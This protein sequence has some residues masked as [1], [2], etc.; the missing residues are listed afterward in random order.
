MTLWERLRAAYGGR[1]V[2]VTGH[3]GFKGSWLVVALDELGAEVSGLALPAVEGGIHR[4][5]GVRRRLVDDLVVDVRDP[6]AVAAAL[7]EQRPELVLHLAAQALVPASFVDPVGTFA[8]NV[9][10][11]AS[12][13]D[14]AARTPGV[15]GVVVVTSDKVYANDG[16][17]RPFR[18]DDRLGGGDPYS[19]SKAAAELV[20]ASWRHSFGRSASS[21]SAPV[22]VTA[23]AGNVIGGGDVGD[24]RLVP[25]AIRSLVAGRP[26]AVRHPDA[27]RPWQHVL[28]PV[29]GYL[30]YGEALLAG[31]TVPPALNFGPQEPAA[32]V[33]SVVDGII[34][35]WGAGS[36][37]ADDADLGPE[38]PVLDLDASLATTELGWQPTPELA[39]ALDLTVAWYRADAAGEDVDALTVAQVHHHLG[40]TS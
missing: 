18:E 12:V 29:T 34:E 30:L 21:P 40:R 32:S 17:G 16:S 11:T 39:T 22:V 26:I 9:V 19:A 8:V 36:W 38:A 33:R 27:R 3:T 23:R 20:V 25:D 5:A 37:V 10:G 2:L 31:R 15:A 6:A 14:A 24:H 13:L 35:R 4:R 28:A 1:R 7:A